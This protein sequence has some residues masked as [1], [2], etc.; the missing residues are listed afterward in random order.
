MSDFTSNAPRHRSRRGTEFLLYFSL[1]FILAIP[2]AT[3][4]WLLD[5]FQKQTLFLHGP[6]ARAWAEADRITPI[7]FSA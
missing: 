2:F 3:V 4:F 6:L 7:L 1:I 5:V